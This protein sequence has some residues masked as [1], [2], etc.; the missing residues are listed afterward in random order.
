MSGPY[1]KS[2]PQNMEDCEC[3]EEECSCP[4]STSCPCIDCE[5]DKADY[6]YECWKDEHLDL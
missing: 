2:D 5:S 1:D 4:H 3:G 6:F